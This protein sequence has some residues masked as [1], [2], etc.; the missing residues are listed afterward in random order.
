VWWKNWIDHGIGQGGVPYEGHL[1][2]LECPNVH[3]FLCLQWATYFNLMSSN[4]VIVF[5]KKQRCLE[6]NVLTVL[7]KLQFGE[8]KKE[9]K[10]IEVFFP[11]EA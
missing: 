6:K 3:Q 8:V 4:N 5:G 9:K 10:V 1:L 7:E 2:H 11:F